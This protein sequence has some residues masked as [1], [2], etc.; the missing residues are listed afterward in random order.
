MKVTDVRTF[1][2][3]CFRTNWVFVKVYTDEGVDG[4]GEATLEYKEKALIGAVEHI[5]DYLIGKNP[6]HIEAH[7]H[8][9]YRDAYWRGGAVLMSALSAVEMALWDILGKHLGVPVYQLMGG[10]VHDEVRIYVNGWF[11]GAK[12]PKEFGEK[13]KAA[14]QKGITAMKWDPF[15]KSYLE[16]SNK[17][18]NTALECVA[19]VR[20]AVGDSVDLLIEGHGRFNIPTGIQIAKELEQFHPMFFEEP[21]PPDNLD[22]LKAVRD[23]SPV[24][25]S[26][27]ERLYTRWDYKRMFDLMAADYIQ[28]DIS[29]A[30]GI[31]ELKKIAA[32]AECRYIPFAPHNPSGPVANAATLQ[33]A[34][35][36]PNFCILEIMYSDVEYRKDITTECLKYKNGFMK[37]PD[38]PGLGIE[39]NEE[40]CL[41]HPYQPHVL[42]HYTGA[43]TD[44]RPPKTEFYF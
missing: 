23:K 13:A 24:A 11:A 26:A 17:E 32:E 30:G 6:F 43:L 25:I 1:A 8:N 16:I 28:P 41:R 4:I 21:V 37:I 42:R 34:A 39:I 31:M 12:T 9:I 27:G 22:A 3:D 35:S 38:R 2:V 36:C 33:L 18:L 14:M 29:H 15:G 10:K 5:K 44:I 7:W 20:A 40:E 19:E